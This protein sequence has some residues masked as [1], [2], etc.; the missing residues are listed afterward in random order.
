MA[1]AYGTT[2]PGNRGRY[3]D[4]YLGADAAAE[5]LPIYH[6]CIRRARPVYTVSTIDD[7]HGRRVVYERLLLPFS[8]DIAVTD[9]IASLKTISDDGGF[10]VANLLRSPDRKPVFA[11][12][13]V[14]DRGPARCA[15]TPAAGGDDIVEI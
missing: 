2:G 8:D 15:A 3:L 6:E 10:E 5:V 7:R 13:A 1:Q 4:E 9:I 12:R 14:I 11:L